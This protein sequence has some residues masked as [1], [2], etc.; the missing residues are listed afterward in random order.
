MK[1]PQKVRRITVDERLDEGLMRILISKLRAGFKNFGDAPDY[2]GKERA[3]LVRPKDY[4]KKM[5]MPPGAAK[6]WPWDSLYEGQVF[7]S[8]GFRERPEE[9]AET[10]FV[11]DAKRMNFQ[12]IDRFSK[13]RVKKSYMAALEGGS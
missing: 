2:W 12:C 4:W 13:D 5:G 6:N 7:L 8:G 11:V 1:N 10:V 3:L 9:S